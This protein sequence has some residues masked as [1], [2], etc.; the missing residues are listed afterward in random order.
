[1]F[2]IFGFF[3]VMVFT[4]RHGNGMAS[5]AHNLEPLIGAKEAASVLNMNSRTLKRY[6]ERGEI[7]AMQIGN[8]WMFLASV[9]DNWRR[10]KLMSN[11]SIQMEQEG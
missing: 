8:R 5:K 2:L 3:T 10:Q 11:C 6:A 1:L 7:P 4:D 9:L